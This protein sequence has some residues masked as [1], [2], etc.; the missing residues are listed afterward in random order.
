MQE[1]DRQ[2]VALRAQENAFHKL[3]LEE[4]DMNTKLQEM[5]KL[6]EQIIT[7]RKDVTTF[8]RRLKVNQGPT[9]TSFV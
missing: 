9:I 6:E 4:R 2:Q 3:E 5:T 7:C 8:T 1:R